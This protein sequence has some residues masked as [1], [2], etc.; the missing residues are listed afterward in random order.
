M[1]G[2]FLS[3]DRDDAGK[4]PLIVQALERAGH[5]VWWDLHVRGGAQ[6]S[7]V[8]DEALKAADAVVV[9][10]SVNSVESAWVR[11]EAAAGR[12][13]GKLVPITLDGTKPPLGFRQ[14]Q[15]ID[16]SKSKGRGKTS[17]LSNLLAAIEA[18]SPVK[19][20]LAPIS[21]VPKSPTPKRNLR[22][23]WLIG[24]GAAVLIAITAFSLTL[25]QPWSR[26]DLAVVAVRPS[27]QG[28]GSQGLARDLLVQLGE[29]RPVLAGSMRLV[30]ATG[31]T[32]ERPDLLF[33]TA[34]IAGGGGA[35]LVL[36]D[37]RDEVLWSKQ[38]ADP[39]ISAAD[40]RQQMAFT[41]ARVLRCALQE[42]SG[43]YG[44]L[45][46]DT[47]QIYLDACASSAEIG[48]DTRSLIL[49]LRKVTLTAPNFRPAWAQLLMADANAVSFAQYS[50]GSTDLSL[51]LRE[52]L[53][54]ARKVFP[55][56]AEVAVAEYYA[57]PNI[58]FRDAV[59]LLDKAKSRD[60]D[61]P[62]VLSE[63]SL[64]MLSVGRVADAIDDA[65]R[66]AQLDPLSPV[67]RTSLIRTL[68]YSGHLDAARAE[69]QRAKQLWPGTETVREAEYGIDLRYGDFEK[70]LRE[71]GEYHGPGPELYV[72]ARKSPTD[73]N[74]ARFMDFLNKN[75]A[76]G[77]RLSFGIQALGEMN[78]VDE[79]YD[80]LAAS[81]VEFAL[82]GNTYV[83]FR[84]W[85]AG[86][87]SD[88][89]FMT[90]AKRTG[91][92]DYWRSSGRWPDFCSDPGLKYDCKAEAAKL[93]GE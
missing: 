43:K 82:K 83:L 63:H 35:N 93:S 80:V 19:S 62:L 22:P 78:R 45:S 28:V 74:V 16:F 25:W 50:P 4:V 1:A 30:N 57:T 46:S 88:P 54:R 67:V 40:Q 26:A 49:P 31:R 18:L 2:V 75:R 81:P 36:S 8:I 85:L 48:W 61:N 71:S 90:V 20:D 60:P 15:T 33:Q 29:L 12:D 10:W 41:A 64:L 11:D 7:K 9:L 91:L 89:R 17:E 51:A 65:R 27:D 79:L 24:A 34:T 70:T 92:V 53:G 56:M 68:A 47:R 87:R 37:S 76:N 5:S 77:D 14:F 21:S 72:A 66:A 55:D 13:S 42:I 84:P 23:I 73:S 39:K 38:F 32:S 52:D 3:Y 44:R 69:L 59:A 58:G 6:F 86:A